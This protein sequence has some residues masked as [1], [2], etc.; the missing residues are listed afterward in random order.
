MNNIKDDSNP[1]GNA[2][3]TDSCSKVNLPKSHSITFKRLRTI[4]KYEQEAFARL[5]EEMCHR[6]LSH[7]CFA[8]AKYSIVSPKPLVQEIQGRRE[9]ELRTD[10][11]LIEI[12]NQN[13]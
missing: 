3:E 2:A 9:V 6:I 7:P 10:I 13:P 8:N 1:K 12:F 5:Q 11:K 4:T